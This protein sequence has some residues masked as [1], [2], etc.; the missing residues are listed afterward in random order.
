MQAILE[1]P[2]WK[3][4]RRNETSSGATIS[5]EGRRSLMSG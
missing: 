1:E 4:P 2:L 3:S 5:A